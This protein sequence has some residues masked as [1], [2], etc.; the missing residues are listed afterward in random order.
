[1]EP[2]NLKARVITLTTELTKS[3]GYKKLLAAVDKDEDKNSCHDYQGKMDWVIERARH[4]AEK[5]NVLPSN[6]LDRWEADRTYWYM[7]YYQ[8]ANQPLITDKNVKVFD[9]YEEFQK[10][11]KARGYRCPLCNGVSTQSGTCNAGTMIPNGPGKDNNK[12]CDWKVNGLLQ[13]PN[14]TV[15]VLIK[16]DLRGDR[17]FIPLSWEDE[18]KVAAT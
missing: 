3:R 14:S 9:T 4:Y 12:K 18:F 2:N 1:M 11:L 7:N 8:E 16:E 15:F 5:L 17:I 10:S 6:V 13:F